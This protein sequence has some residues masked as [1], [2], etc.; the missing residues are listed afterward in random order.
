ME[1]VEDAHL[2]REAS[3]APTQDAALPHLPSLPLEVVH[4]GEGREEVEEAEGEDGEVS[5]GQFG[6]QCPQW[7]PPLTWAPSLLVLVLGRV[8]M[9][10]V[11][12]VMVV[13]LRL[14]VEVPCMVSATCTRA[15][16]PGPPGWCTPSSPPLAR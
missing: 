14:S 3:G 16:P 4:M 2:S 12:S 8:D 7:P 9:V 6:P 11:V 13:L 5:M 15:C 1:G 10:M